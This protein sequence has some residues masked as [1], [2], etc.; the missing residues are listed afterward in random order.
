MEDE[1]DARLK[2]VAR[3]IG[4]LAVIEDLSKDTCILNQNDRFKILKI[5]VQSAP[6]GNLSTVQ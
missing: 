6:R 2:Q 3:H 1:W 4:W 5:I